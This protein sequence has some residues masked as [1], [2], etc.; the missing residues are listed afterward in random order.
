[1]GNKKSI[2][3]DQGNVIFKEV[4]SNSSSSDNTNSKNENNQHF[5]ISY[6]LE[7]LKV[8]LDNVINEIKVNIDSPDSICIHFLHDKISN[9]ANQITSLSLKST[10]QAKEV[11]PIDKILS[12]FQLFSQKND[13]NKLSV[14]FEFLQLKQQHFETLIEYIKGFKNLSLLDLR[15]NNDLL[16]LSTF[17]FLQCQS[18]CLKNKNHL[19]QLDLLFSFKNLKI[20]SDNFE[21]YL[22]AFSQ[23]LSIE[24]FNIS[25]EN[26]VYSDI[27]L[28]IIYSLIQH[29]H[30]Q[31]LFIDILQYDFKNEL[32]QQFKT[33]KYFKYQDNKQLIFKSNLKSLIVTKLR[34]NNS[35][36]IFSLASNLEQLETLNVTLIPTIDQYSDKVLRKVQEFSSAKKKLENLI[37]QFENLIPKECM[38]DIVSYLSKLQANYFKFSLPYKRNYDYFD[39]NNIYQIEKYLLSVC[40]NYVEI[41]NDPTFFNIINKYTTQKDVILAQYVIFQKLQKQHMICNPQLIFLDLYMY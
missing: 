32:S 1:M 35:H 37:I 22:D 4:Y 21:V 36:V 24:H 20:S 29:Q 13:L 9:I 27:A 14:R 5:F 23:L 25:I 41:G 3:S 16:D 6:G 38:Y 28:D 7:S 18:I 30:L 11:F 17:N 8:Y 2:Q 15:L 39:R 33:Q 31:T 34:C 40:W 19:K 12:I 10:L 26:M